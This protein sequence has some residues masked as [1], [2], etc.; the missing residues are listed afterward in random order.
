MN[1]YVAGNLKKIYLNSKS[2]TNDE[3]ILDIIK[4][5][6]KIDF[7]ERSRNICVPKIQHS[8]KEIEIVNSEIQKLLDKGVIVQFD[9]E[10]NDFVSTVFTTEEK[11]GSSRTI[12]NLKCLNEF[13]R[14]RHFKMES[15][16]DVLKTI[17]TDV[18]MANS[19][20]KDAFFTVPVHISHQ[21]YFKFGWFQNF[22][23]FLGMPNGDSDAMRI[24]TKIRKSVFGHLRNQ[25][26]IFLIFVDD[27]YL[28]GDTKHECMNNI[29][30]TIDFFSSLGFSIHTGKSV[31]IPTQKVEFLG[32]LID[33][34][35]MKI[36][37]TN[38][39]TEHLTLK[40]KKF[41]VNKSPNIRQLASI[42]GSVISIFHAVPLGKM[43][44]RDL[45]REKVSFLKKES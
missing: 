42:I 30:A 3:I 16:S 29:I 25:G 32:F 4:N 44:Y 23:K 45:E 38:K 24:F 40:I 1:K 37:L 26:H 21:K 7:K 9:R 22:Y 8:T 12:L 27:S 5:G 18:W 41:L 17:K 34:K 28:Q 13:V 36:S 43:H 11:D 19:D 14:Y 31:L 2:I 33:S 10:P 15:L 35:N 20:L 6:C 39:K